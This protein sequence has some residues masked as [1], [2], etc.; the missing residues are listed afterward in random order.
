MKNDLFLIDISD[1]LEFIEDGVN[2]ARAL[3]A[4][5]N[6]SVDCIMDEEEYKNAQTWIFD[7]LMADLQIAR[8]EVTAERG[9]K[10]DE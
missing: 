8:A 5:R 7:H 3:A 4:G 9:R 1:K 10:M 2:A 6:D